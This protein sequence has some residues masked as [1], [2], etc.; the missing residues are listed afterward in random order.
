MG[1]TALEI[2]QQALIEIGV[3]AIPSTILGAENDVRRVRSLLQAESRYLRNQR[4]FPCVKRIYTFTASSNRTKYPLPNDFY[5]PLTGTLWDQSNQWQLNGPLSDEQFTKLKLDNVSIGVVPSF[6][7]FGIDSNSNTSGGQFELYPQ[8]ESGTIFYYEYIT[9]HLFLPPYWTP[10]TVIASNSYRNSNGN[11]YF[12][13]AGG[14]T[15]TTPPSATTS[16]P[17]DG[18]VTW[19]LYNLP[20]ENILTDQDLCMYDDDILI[21]GVKW[22]Y[23]K[24]TGT[25]YDLDPNTGVPKMHQKL[26]DAS[27]CRFNGGTKIS[28]MGTNYRNLNLPEG[29][30]SL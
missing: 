29:N 22:R 12:T 10:S 20:Y 21:S 13:T 8:P 26:I 5:M 23:E 24:S 25:A 30:W 18:T 15:G 1:L 2:C 7:I 11:I 4:F 6:R 14:T 19:N 9:K 17:T 3:G 28:L 16:I 27:L